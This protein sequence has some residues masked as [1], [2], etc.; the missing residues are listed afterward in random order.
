LRWLRAYGIHL[1]SSTSEVFV[2]KGTLDNAMVGIADSITN[3]RISS[4]ASTCKSPSFGRWIAYCNRQLRPLSRLLADLSRMH[5]M[6]M[7]ALRKLA[8]P[9]AAAANDRFRPIADLQDKVAG[10][11]AELINT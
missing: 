3:P 9:F 8:Q 7:S 1:T 10:Y 6:Q 4:E 2:N 11:D 5:L